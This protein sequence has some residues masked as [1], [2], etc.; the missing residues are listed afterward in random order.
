[1]NTITMNR[2]SDRFIILAQ[3]TSLL[4][5]LLFCS[6]TPYA[7]LI[8]NGDGTVTDTISRL[9]W[10][11]TAMDLDHDNNPD[12]L[13]WENALAACKNLNLG[14]HGDWR[15]PNILELRSI[16]DYSRHNPAADPVFPMT[17]MTASFTHWSSTTAA[18]NKKNAWFFYLNNGA[19]ASGSKHDSYYVRAVR[20]VQEKFPW[21]IFLPT[22]TDMGHNTP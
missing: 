17:S 12:L 8:D 2:L 16:V 7:A 19:H 4:L 15:L 18:M 9:Q 13:D 5:A 21:I 11:K 22:I 6:T 20:D 10:Q 1:M 14:G 3:T